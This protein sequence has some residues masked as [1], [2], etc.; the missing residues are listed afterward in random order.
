MEMQANGRSRTRTS[1]LL[2]VNATRP[3]LYLVFIAK[4]EFRYNKI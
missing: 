3:N 4:T 1:D 2:G